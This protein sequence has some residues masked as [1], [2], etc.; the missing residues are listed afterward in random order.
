LLQ[1]FHKNHKDSKTPSTEYDE[2]VEEAICFGW[3]DSKPNKRDDESYY[4]FVAQRKLKSNWRKANRVRAEKVIGQGLMTAAEQAM[5]DP[6]KK[7]GI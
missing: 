7:T 3:V 2:A 4:L 1:A 6:A 5:I